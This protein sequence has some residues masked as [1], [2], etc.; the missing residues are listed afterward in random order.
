[1]DSERSFEKLAAETDVL[2]PV[3]E[4]APARLKSRIYSALLTPLAATGSA[5]QPV[6]NAGRRT[7]ALYLRGSAMRGPSGRT[8]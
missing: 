3:E 8:R 5:A 1:M 6:C 2:D 4:R 7:P